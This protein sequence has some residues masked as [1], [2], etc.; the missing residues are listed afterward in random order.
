MTDNVDFSDESRDR[1]ILRKADYDDADPKDLVLTVPKRDGGK[2][3]IPLLKHARSNMERDDYQENTLVRIKPL[4]EIASDLPVRSGGLTIYQGKGVALLRPGFLY[5]FRKDKLW[6]E[7]EISQNS[8]FSDIDLEATR[9]EVGDPASDFRMVRPSAGQWL[10]DVLVPVF[11]QGQAVMHDFRMAFSEVQWDWSYIQKLEESAATRNARTTGVGHAWAVTSVDSLSFET[12][13]PASRVEDVPELRH[14]DLGIE[15]MIENPSDFAPSFEGPGNHELCAKLAKLLRQN[16]SQTAEAVSDSQVDASDDGG[17]V[18]EMLEFSC[19]QGMDLL[20]DLRRH[21]GVACVALPDPLFELR[22]SLT[23]LHLAMHYLDAVDVSIQKNPMAHSAM[24]IRQAVFDPLPNGRPSVLANY[25]T[26]V[27]REKLDEVLDTPEKNHAIR[28]IE[29]HVD[30]LQHKI[31]LRSLDVFFEDYRECNDLAICE[32]YLLIADQLNVLQQIPGVLRAQGVSTG[33]RVLTRLR[34]WLLDGNFLTDWA[35][36]LTGRQ[37]RSAGSLSPFEKLQKLAR[38]QAEID[39]GLLDRLNIQSLVY[40][41][42]QVKEKQDGGDSI[43]KDLSNAGKIGGLISG[44][45]GEWSSS[46]LTVCKRLI[47]EGAIQQIEIQRI[48]QAASSNLILTDPALKDIDVVNRAGAVTRG[49][50]IGVSGNGLKRGLTDFD[51]VD[52][53]LTRKSDYLYAD[54]LDDADKLVASSSPTRAAQALDDAIQKAAGGTTVFFVPEGHPEA[55]KLGLLK[56]D[57]AKRVGKIVDG[58]AVSR[59]L[60]VLAAFNVFLEAH[61]VSQVLRQQNGNLTLATSKVA[62]AFTDLVAASLKLSL[63]LE[64]GAVQTTSVHKFATRPLFDMKNWIFIGNR[65]KNLSVGT[66]VRTVGLATFITGTITV[67]LSSWEMRISFSNKDFDAAAGHAI[68]VTGALV[69][70]AYPLM[71]ALLAIPGWGWA[72]LGMSMVVGGSLYANAVRDDSFERLLK[73]GPWGTYPDTSLMELNDQAYYSQLLSL[74]SPI[75]VTAQRYADIDPDPELSHPSYAP[76]PDDYVVTV[77]FPL[78][79]RLQLYRG[80]ECRADFPERSFNLVVQEVAYQSSSTSI[81]SPGSI[82]PVSATQLVKATP[83]TKVTARQSLPHQSAV[84]FLVKREFQD[85]EYLSLFYQESVSTRVR[86]GLQVILD[87]E[88]G[89]LIFPAPVYEN[90]EPFD[91]VVHGNPP[92]KERTI[93]DPYAQPKSPYWYFTEVT[94]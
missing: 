68:A 4:A 85:S 70:M 63:V 58:P 48:M 57:F 1:S 2:I 56:V 73:R 31:N 42:K 69:F 22:H 12:G 59:G 74:L 77:Q 32:A 75:R 13:F 92:P 47:E 55:Q 40:L 76:E 67:V 51:R 60:V 86:V 52:G 6:R 39:E 35:P 89:P 5:I 7:L 21:K 66:L 79:S 30:D 71:G 15:L 88:L 82:A 46:V 27:D 62:G 87:T 84:R 34:E 41:E 93:L 53:V 72:I 16:Q 11:L 94:V 91:M 83:L 80:Y 23:Q 90:F 36:Q 19:E 44:A 54:M 28:V 64:S 78:I 43:F 18:P 20:W 17:E 65:L 29:K 26:A 10:D 45:L 8:Q 50:I 3:S 14:R 81:T 38:E 33:D 9:A 61:A 24:L 25:A 37:G 49:S